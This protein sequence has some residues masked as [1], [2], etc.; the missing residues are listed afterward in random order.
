MSWNA[1][2][3]FEQ[4][5]TA[6]GP[7][8]SFQPDWNQLFNDPLLNEAHKLS[9]SQPAGYQSFGQPVQPS[10]CVA[11]SQHTEHLQCGE[12]APLSNFPADL[13]STE[14]WLLHQD[15]AQGH[16]T[17]VPENPLRQ[18]DLQSGSEGQTKCASRPGEF[19]EL[20]Q[21]VEVLGDRCE[22]LEDAVPKLQ[23]G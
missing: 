10:N 2:P 3:Q 16:A 19:Q 11:F 14:V 20:K 6:Q 12:P 22:A 7:S 4:F 21:A 5:S 1:P 17:M 9:F 13:L 8:V 18:V 15:V 23:D